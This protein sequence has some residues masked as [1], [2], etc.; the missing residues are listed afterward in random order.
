VK[1]R[2]VTSNLISTYGFVEL[3]SLLKSILWYPI[4]E[5]FLY[6]LKYISSRLRFF[7]SAKKPKRS[8]N[9]N[10]TFNILRLS[11]YLK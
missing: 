7:A 4:F 2:K 3:L 8:A 1:P 10:K 9:D 11:G 6:T 5:P